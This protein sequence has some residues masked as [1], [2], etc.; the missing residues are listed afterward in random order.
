MSPLYVRLIA[1]IVIGMMCGC[2]VTNQTQVKAYVYVEK[3]LGEDEKCG[4]KIELISVS[5]SK[6]K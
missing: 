2:S 6:T 1:I 4:A 3:D 5:L